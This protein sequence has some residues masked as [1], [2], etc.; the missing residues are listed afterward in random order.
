MK[1]KPKSYKLALANTSVVDKWTDDH[2]HTFM[3]LKSRLTTAPTCCAPRYNHEFVVGT[4]AYKYGYG[5]FLAQWHSDPTPDSPT[6]H[7]LHPVAFASK[8]THL[9]E[10][11]AHSFVQ[12]LA[13][14]KFALERFSKYI[15][16]CPI[17]L[18]TDCQSAKDLLEKT[19]LPAAHMQHKEFIPP[20]GQP[21]PSTAQ[22]LPIQQMVL[23]TG[24]SCP[25]RPL[26][27]H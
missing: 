15:M 25:N 26:E 8:R 9:S 1:M 22:E 4:D 20:P 11:H 6:R 21:T 19:S 16:G 10:Q 27:S 2:G 3:T 5:T 24:P 12:E 23:P 14:L 7:M 17:I 18:A 13:G